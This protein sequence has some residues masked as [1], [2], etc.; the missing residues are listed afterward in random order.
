VVAH[1]SSEE[2][3]F[4]PYQSRVTRGQQR[5]AEPESFKVVAHPTKHTTSHI[6]SSGEA[7]L[8]LSSSLPQTPCHR[9]HPVC[10]VCVR[11]RAC[12]RA[13]ACACVVR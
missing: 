11:V 12:V 5:F 8:P 3:V 7:V 1:V 4:A 9:S 13:C 2:D 10:V 6:Q